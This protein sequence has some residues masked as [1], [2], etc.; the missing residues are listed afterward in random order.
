MLTTK[1]LHTA[2]R[3]V[4]KLLI[5][6]IV[7]CSGFSAL[8]AQVGSTLTPLSPVPVLMN[9][10]EIQQSKIWTY[11]GKHWCVL[12]TSAGTII[13]RLD[14]TTWTNVFTLA[15]GNSIKADIKTV[16]NVVHILVY[17]GSTS[18]LYSVE[19]VDATA[20]YRLWTPR[21]T[22]VDFTM[23][24]SSQ[25]ATI[26]IDATGRMWMVSDG[27]RDVNVRWSDSPY[28]VW[29]APIKL[30]TNTATGDL[31]AVVALPGKIGVF[32]SNKVTRRF[33]FKTHTNGDDPATWSDD[34][35]PASQSALNIGTG[36]AENQF[37]L[38]VAT[39]GRLYVSI[40]TGYNSA[41]NTQLALLVRQTSGNWDAAYPVTVG[42]G[43]RPIVIL[44]E[45]L[46]VLK[47]I[48]TL[49]GT[50]AY[51]QS[52]LYPVSFGDEA[53]LL[54][55]AYDNVSSAKN[56]YNESAVVLASTATSAA[57]VLIEDELQQID[58]TPPAVESIDRL[59]PS[60]QTTSATTVTYRVLFS[61]KV[62][63]VN[64][65]D[66]SL[67]TISGTADGTLATDAVT[68]VGTAGTT[69]DV[70]VTAVNGTGTLRLDLKSAGT[71]IAD[72]AGNN[73]T[74]GF[75]TGQTYIITQAA[76]TLTSV[77]IASDNSNS[78][79]AKTGDV[80][81]LSF[82][83]SR[84]I[85]Q[86][87]VTIAGHPVTA[88]AQG[89]NSYEASR[90]LAI[91]D[92]E[93]QI[94]FSID[95]TA[96]DGTDG[97]T[98]S[99][100][101]NNSK[102]I[103]DR[104]DP[105]AQTINRQVPVTQTVSLSSVT[106]RVVFSE[107]VTGVTSDDFALSV[108][109][110]TVT[111]TIASDAV[112]AVGTAGTTYDVDVTSIDNAGT[113]RINLK[114]S[115]TSITDVAGNSISGG[116]TTGQTYI[117][118]QPAPVLNTVTIASDNANNAL[119][120][121]G[122][123]VT[124]SFTAS[125]TI[126]T[127][128]VT[129]AGDAATATAQ[130][131]NSYKATHTLTASD[132]E[133]QVPFT[134]DFTGTNGTA[135][136]TVDATTNSSKVTFDKTEPTAE[137]VDRQNP[138]GQSITVTTATYRVVFSEKVTGVNATD[139]ILTIVSGSVTG[140][141]AS[142]A[143]SPVGSAGTTYDVAIS[144]IAGNGTLRLDVKSSGT[145]I[146]D[147]AGNE[148]DEAFTTGETYIKT[149]PTVI[150]GFASFTPLTPLPV[151]TETKDKPQS[152]V[153][154]YANKWWTV[155]S[156]SGGT[157]VYR[158]DGVTWTAV[159][160]LAST[161]ARCDIK[162][163]GPVVHVLMYKGDGSTSL[164]YSLEHVPSNN[165]YKLWTAR[166]VRAEI[167]FP[168]GTETANMVIDGNGRMWATTTGTTQVYVYYS[169]YPYSTFSAKI[170]I[171]SGIKDDDISV[172]TA[173]P[174]EN[175]ISVLWSNQTTKRFNFR[176]HTD[177]TDPT[178]WS[179]LET[180]ASQS[181][182]DNI[183][184]GMA[185]DHLNAKVTSNGTYY[186]ATKTGYNKN[187]YAKVALLVRRPNGVWDNLYTV[188]SNPD[189][190]QPTIIINESKGTLK[191][192]YCS[193]ENGGK[194][195]YRESPLNTIA[196]GPVKTLISN[197]STLYDYVSS[198]SENYTSEIVLIATNLSTN[199]KSVVGVLATDDESGSPV[200][201]DTTAGVMIEPAETR[202]AQLTLTQKATVFPNPFTNTTTLNFTLTESA[203]YT[204]MLYD[205]TG[206]LLGVIKQGYG[207]SGIQNS[208]RINQAGLA[209]GV[210]FLRVQTQKN[211]QTFKVLKK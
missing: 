33:A 135:G 125:T 41:S 20:N 5:I 115:G 76:P 11:A 100:T 60:G 56:P 149:T 85:N 97:V 145:G 57:G 80:V 210:Y 189:G 50:I 40:K 122:D 64:V 205:Q 99:A 27:L 65:S 90:T 19:Y 154:K 188:S 35:A 105:D 129:I 173:L 148:L 51:K 53:T 88:V 170:Q 38:K 62:T 193:L 146:I 71:G 140:A 39:S 55:E 74:D 42:T 43:L 160:T 54:N 86:P 198:A 1:K 28:S 152:K 95:F 200:V 153:W 10:A 150:D 22:R 72:V 82:T 79:V 3:S 89:G 137:S 180:P 104:T 29:S 34:E 4:S 70:D 133:G 199:P 121:V 141:L 15:S 202:P 92:D 81:T 98:V 185:D 23:E 190:T 178:A 175:K 91:G 2:C 139:F 172:I 157:K 204:V 151:S 147:Q 183:G 36:F 192:V 114:G 207:N 6:I 206:L 26:D 177:G 63:G 166:P 106:Y 187:G 161:S 167:D 18:V 171:G 126:Q 25:T 195:I 7:V 182:I 127:P 174:N 78:A 8:H 14:G 124:L 94:P 77:T 179:T 211:S 123:V 164:L 83:A 130:G 9:T 116:F 118:S 24:A 75:T 21:K 12:G 44:N 13:M 107:K 68:P 120:K 128:D 156:V 197:G 49:N 209:A 136:V 203:R 132:A 117:I 176:T 109:S 73:I 144:S 87:V 113:F 58:N 138:S 101:T 131:G 142:N 134:I 67:S 31:C 208:I 37:N 191:I 103:F 159:L 59:T 169:D 108:V 66:F 111:A 102:V 162:T 186:C 96:T 48:Y 181:A 47:V 93:G 158:L 119:A 143:V 196:F 155:L 184:A 52:P 168:S 84:T 61:E 194:I 17:K 110:G 32:W 163:V 69:Y 46:D 45:T 201:L 16:G 165:T 30:E 112:S